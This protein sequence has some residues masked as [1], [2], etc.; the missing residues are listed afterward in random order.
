LA[1]GANTIDDHELLDE[2][3][4]DL[5]DAAFDLVDVGRPPLPELGE[6]LRGAHD[7]PREQLWEEGDVESVVDEVRS[8]LDVPAGHVD[9]VRD[10][11]E[12]VEAD[13]DRNQQFK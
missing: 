10:A 11:L 6:E 8:R 9:K 7:R 1:I 13:P 3:Q 4:H 5:P 2:A 12:C